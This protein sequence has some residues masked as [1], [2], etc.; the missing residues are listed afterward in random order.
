MKIY[1]I[2][3]DH[4]EV[5]RQYHELRSD[6]FGTD[7]HVVVDVDDCDRAFAELM[8]PSLF[9]SKKLVRL[10]SSLFDKDWMELITRCAVYDNPLRTMVVRDVGKSLDRRKLGKLKKVDNV[11][12]CHSALLDRRD[13][14]VGFALK[15]CGATGV[16]FDRDAVE[17]L[18]AVVGIDRGLLASEI[19]K[20]ASLKVRLTKSIVSTYAF[21]SSHEC[22]HFILYS[23]I[24]DGR[25]ADAREQTALLMSDGIPALAI[26]ASIL[27]L[28]STTA[29][30]AHR[31][32]PVRNELN[33]EWMGS[34]QVKDA[35]AFMANIYRRIFER[36]GEERILNMIEQSTAGLAALRL[37]SV[38][39]I[40]KTRVDRLIG[41]ICRE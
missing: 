34:E 33:E 7:Q 38:V 20:L 35:T 27:K 11:V 23:A 24:A 4:Y 18:V 9:G 10:D 36:M 41:A 1:F 25:E 26:L 21:P 22:A 15:H 30:G 31:Y 2:T 14:A 19:D 5:D 6:F 28:L 39:D 29:A 40:E 13:D 32:I 37:S 8:T 16:E 17:L 3:G 12:F